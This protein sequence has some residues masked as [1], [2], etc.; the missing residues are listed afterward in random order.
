MDADDLVEAVLDLEAERHGP[1][2]VETARPAGDDALDQRIGLAADARGD[3]VAGDALQGRDLLADRD[4][5][6]RHGQVDAVAELLPRQPYGVEEE[7]DRRTRAGVPVHHTLRHRQDRLLPGERL[8]DDAGE[9]TRGRLVRLARAHG[10]GRQADADAV[11]EAAAI[12]IGE[13]EFAHRL[14]RAVGG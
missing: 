13:Q 4:R 7:P 9:E 5:D 6:A 1:P 3:L 2:G 11:E 8:A 12:V 14:L 10:N